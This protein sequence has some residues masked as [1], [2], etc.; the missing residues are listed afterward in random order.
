LFYAPLFAFAAADGDEGRGIAA[1]C[2][3]PSSTNPEK[4]GPGQSV[5]RGLYGQLYTPSGFCR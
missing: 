3:Q 2:R 4:Q 1:L 5:P